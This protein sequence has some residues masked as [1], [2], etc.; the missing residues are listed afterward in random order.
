VSKTIASMV[1]DVQL[2]GIRVEQKLVDDIIK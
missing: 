2:F 1:S